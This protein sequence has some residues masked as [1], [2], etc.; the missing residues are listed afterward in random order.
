MSN[1]KARMCYKCGEPFYSIEEA[2]THTCEFQKLVEIRMAYDFFSRL[3]RKSAG[4]F[5]EKKAN[6]TIPLMDTGE[7]A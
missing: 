2:V 4:S 1:S 7:V 3:Q 6:E 5:L